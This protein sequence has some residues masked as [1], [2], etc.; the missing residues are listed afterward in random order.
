MA[1]GQW[2]IAKKNYEK[3]TIHTDLLACDCFGG[4]CRETFCDA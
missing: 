3:D 1:N 2:L 4:S